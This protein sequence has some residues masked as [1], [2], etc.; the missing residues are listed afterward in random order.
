MRGALAGTAL[1]EVRLIHVARSDYLRELLSEHLA[2][3]AVEDVLARMA[4]HTRSFACEATEST[5][6][7]EQV[8]SGR[9]RMS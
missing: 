7:A 5:V 8:S 9:P 3:N 1:L 4:E 6:R 2:V